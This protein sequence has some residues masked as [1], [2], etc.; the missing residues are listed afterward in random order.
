MRHITAVV[1][2]VGVFFFMLAPVV[3]ARESIEWLRGPEGLAA[4]KE[5]AADENKLLLLDFFHPD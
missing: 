1:V 3:Q 4:A 2:L 5:K